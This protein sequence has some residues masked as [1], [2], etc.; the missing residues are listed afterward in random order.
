[1]YESYY[2]GL[3]NLS[4][5]QL[6]AERNAFYVS[7]KAIL[8]HPNNKECNDQ[9]K[10]LF[11]PSDP[12]MKQAKKVELYDFLLPV[13][14]QELEA[15][16]NS[17]GTAAKAV[18]PRL[19]TDSAGTGF[20]A[21]GEVPKLKSFEGVE[22]FGSNPAAVYEDSLF[23]AYKMDSNPRGICLIINMATFEKGHQHLTPRRGA[24]NDKRV[25]T[26]LFQDRLHFK[27]QVHNDLDM[28]TLE[29]LLLTAS[30]IDHSKYDAF[31][32]CFLTHG[33]LGV[34]Y[35]SD[36]KPI[37]I[38]DVTDYFNDKNCPT[39]RGKPK[40]FFIQACMKGV[41]DNA[42]DNTEG[43]QRAV[44]S[45]GSL[46]PA[47]PTKTGQAGDESMD[48]SA[49]VVT[50]QIS[51]MAAEPDGVRIVE[52]DA[53][54][55]PTLKAA[56]DPE[57]R[58]WLESKATLVPGSPD[59]VMSYATLP[60]W[61][62]FRDVEFGS[63]YVNELARCLAQHHEIDRALRLVTK[64]V[65]EELKKADNTE[66]KPH[67]QLPFHLMTGTGKLLRLTK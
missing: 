47:R 18:G 17:S 59:F 37:R 58:F 30:I 5:D 24:D 62:A 44:D 63:L 14:R 55:A 50:R 32:C 67:F 57:D 21:T 39:L 64:G 27:V 36:A 8:S 52:S 53:N 1:M 15:Q 20:I 60:G 31:A 11:W 3:A 54:V 45:A 48:P 16:R 35:T 51:E 28:E 7:L 25:L 33:K 42:P 38:L 9:F 12:E 19:E 23:G 2:F 49:T 34:L 6:F 26:E 66:N 13:V 61:V 43:G 41:E 40:L 65:V 22:A 4:L 46:G 10:L 29:K 56:N